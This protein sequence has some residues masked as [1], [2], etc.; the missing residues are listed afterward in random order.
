V[1]PDATVKTTVGGR[2]L[3]VSNLDKVLYPDSG[4]T[5][6][7]MLDY[8]ARIAPFMLAHLSDRPLTMKRYPEGVQ[9]PFF[10]EK[11]APAGS[12]DWLPRVLVPARSE[13][14]PIQYIAIGDLPG[15]MWAANLASIEF[16]VPLWHAGRRRILPGPPDHMVFDLDPG[17]GTSIVE[18]CL[19]GLSIVEVLKGQ[20]LPCFPKTSGSKG[21]QLYTPLRGRPTWD[22]VRTDSHQIALQIEQELP[23]LVVSKMRKDLRRGKVLIDWSQNHP[24][25]TTVA[26]YSLRARPYPTV[27]TPVTWQEVADCADRGSPDLLTFTVDEV[28]RRVDTLGDLFAEV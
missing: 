21:L 5:K 12:P 11:H 24:A 28:L 6:G 2:E 26:A 23:D 16:H 20:H 25:K 14:K 4:F 8:Y 10:F 9:G 22:K 13:H 3:T 7:Q 15:L 19:V 18:C 17:D 1:S 27:S